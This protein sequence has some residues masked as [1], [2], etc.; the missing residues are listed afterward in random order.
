MSTTYILLLIALYFGVLLLISYLTSKEDSNE[1]F[2]RANKNAP[3]YLVAFG[4]VGASLSGIT[5]ISVPGWVATKNFSYLQMVLGFVVGYFV[6][7]NVLLPLYYKMNLTSIYTY[8]EERFGKTAH[9]TGAFLF[10][11]ARIAGASLRLFL[12]AT[13]LQLLIF[14]ELGVP[15]VVTVTITI[16]LIWVY[17][18]KGGIKT[19]IWTDTLQT[20]FMLVALGISSYLIADDL[21]LS[22]TGVITTVKESE[23]SQI[24]FFDDYNAGNYFWKQF[25]AGIF[26]A[27]SMTGLDQ[28]MM[29]KNLTVNTLK[30]SQKNM[31]WFSI[32]LL[33]VNLLF[34][35]LG[36]LLL[37]Y[38]AHNHID[39]EALNIKGDTIFPHIA[40][41]TNLGV[42]AAIFFVLGLI[43]AAYS[44]ADSSMTAI[45]TSFSIDILEIDKKYKPEKQK[46][47]RK[48]VH[49]GISILFVFVLILYNLLITD[50]SIISAIFKFAGY[51]YGPLL[52]LFVFGLYTKKRV[53]DKWV[54]F[55][56][57]LSPILT[58]IIS[59][60]P[61][62]LGWKYRFSFELLLVNAGL[63][64]LG[65]L[66]I[67]NKA[68]E[69]T[70]P[71]EEE[72]IL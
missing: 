36:V 62:F 23:Y 2:F 38:A 68:K 35:G 50:R 17:T 58:Y 16:L 48:R 3:W 28:G 6:I 72:A 14:D 57:I 46:R 13:V 55:I 39:L 32:A 7:A 43:A 69:K 10:L 9:K 11:I 19:I 63:T 64:I 33:F 5:F 34:L 53:Q 12:V 65:L 37:K 71:Q 4:M 60:L 20:L 15:F 59:I 27:V 52:G 21:N 54:P 40:V 18:F 67:Q 51:T 42:A 24:F 41:K 47:I 66:L 44:S 26:I 45:T 49:I 30:D 22:L 61:E 70:K 56:V 8:L 31:Y 1:E 29:Q 25:L